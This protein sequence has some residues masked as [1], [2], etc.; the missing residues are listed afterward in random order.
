MS[1]PQHLVLQLPI[2][3]ISPVAFL[4]DRCENVYVSGW[5]G[6]LYAGADPYGLA[7][8]AG[9]PIS[10]NAIKKITDNRDFYFIVIQKNA[11]AL[12]YATYFGQMDGPRSI[13]EH[14]D[15]GTSRYDKEGAIYQAICANCAG[16]SLT[17]FP[18]SPGVWSPRNGTGGEG[19]NLA[20]VK[21]AFN[22]AGVSADPRSL[23]DGRYDSSG[24]VPLTGSFC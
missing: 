10:P 7:G 22:F 6:W 18:T 1:I 8:T 23:I 19:C 5:G 24:C 11:S 15:G 9:M 21:I 20:A 13:S 16:N 12:L 4:V 14:V 3:N 17:P 2:P